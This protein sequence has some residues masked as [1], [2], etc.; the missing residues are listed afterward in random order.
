RAFL[1]PMA[2]AL[3]I[4]SPPCCNIASLGGCH[5]GYHKLMAMPQWPIAQLGSVSVTVVNA[6]TASAYQNECRRATARSKCCWAGALHAIGKW[7]CPSFSVCSCA[8]SRLVQHSTMT[9][10]PSDNLQLFMT[11]L[12]W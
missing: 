7:T 4:A 3:A 1:P 6:F 11:H 8:I 9:P 10:T 12:Q 5:R 2:L